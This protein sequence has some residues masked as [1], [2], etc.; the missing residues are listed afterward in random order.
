M[1]ILVLFIFIIVII[2]AVLAL[3]TVFMRDV[4]F[5]F[6]GV[7]ALNHTFAIMPAQATAG[8]NLF[9]GFDIVVALTLAFMQHTPITA[10]L[11]TTIVIA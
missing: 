11:N 10:R 2:F 9:T 8:A 5:H 6:L 7:D 4:P 1:L 3:M